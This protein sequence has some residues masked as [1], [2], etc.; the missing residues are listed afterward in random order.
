MA[1]WLG[2]LEG[3]DQGHYRHSYDKTLKIKLHI[4]LLQYN[5]KK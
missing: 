1:N 4:T 2:S 5:G 3:H